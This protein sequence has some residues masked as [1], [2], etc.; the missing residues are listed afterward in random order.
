MKK[1]LF[2]V[3]N[4][5]PHTS[6]GAIVSA[7][8]VKKL[9]KTGIEVDVL[10]TQDINNVVLEK[11]G[12]KSVSLNTQSLYVFL[13]K[14]LIRLIRRI[15][16]FINIEDLLILEYK[17]ISVVLYNTTIKYLKN[18]EYVSIFSITYP[19]YNHLLGELLNIDLK[20]KWNC[21]Y[22]DPFYN[23]SQFKIKSNKKLKEFELLTIKNSDTIFIPEFLKVDYCEEYFEAI[24]NK[25]ETLNLP[26]IESLVPNQH[27]KSKP[28]QLRQSI[29]VI[30]CAYLGS[31][32]SEIRN[33]NDLFVLW[34]KIGSDTLF[35]NCYGKKIGNF[36]KNYFENWSQILHNK[37]FIGDPVPYTQVKKI[38]TE[39][40]IL[41]NIGNKTLNQLPSK[42]IEY[43]NTGKPIINIYSRG[44]SIEKMLVD[45]Y[46]IGFNISSE[47]V[48][49]ETKI[50]ELL[51]FI[52]KNK[53]VVIE[54]EE[55]YKIYENYTMDKAIISIKNHM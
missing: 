12:G 9:R 7:N 40:N 24:Y 54:H 55:V 51:A 47:E 20:T 49:D 11:E 5:I 16:N 1:H 26:L 30:K 17:L 42:L 36:K 39:T 22:F 6:G 8:I 3:G 28:P 2:I 37:A 21:I 50:S 43:I 52:V 53:D 33:P 48:N 35:L 29:N 32:Y 38:L 25:I 18:E 31:F 44:D 45:K 19:F 27:S 23:N 10:I 14:Y 13:L 46:P 41:I 34:D 4:Y 15:N